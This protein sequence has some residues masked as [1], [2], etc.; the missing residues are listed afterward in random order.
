MA[1]GST[2]DLHEDCGSDRVIVALAGDDA[3]MNALRWALSWFEPP[4][5]C[6]RI[7]VVES[8]RVRRAQVEQRLREAVAGLAAAPARL[9]DEAIWWTR[10]APVRIH[11][12]GRSI[13][14]WL[15]PSDVLVI[16]SDR[17]SR[18]EGLADTSLPLYVAAVARSPVVAVPRTWQRSDS[19]TLLVGDNED[20]DAALR[21]ASAQAQL[22]GAPLELVHAWQVAPGYPAALAG[23]SAGYLAARRAAEDALSGRAARLRELAPGLPVVERLLEGPRVPV[24]LPILRASGLAVLSRRGSGVLRDVVLGS[25]AHELV[26]ALPCPLAVVPAGHPHDRSTPPDDPEE[27]SRVTAG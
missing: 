18:L 17:P 10:S 8:S 15:R 9:V 16:G 1:A 19:V 21:F 2:S 6:L 20:G 7:L 13:V 24:L 4:P 11:P 26:G 3:G 14:A 25:L 5:G 22:R 12:L 23:E 27:Q